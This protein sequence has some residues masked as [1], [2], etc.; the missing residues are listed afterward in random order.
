MT[1]QQAVSSLAS[2]RYLLDEMAEPERTTFEEHYFSCSECAEDVRAGAVM[3]EG[4]RAGWVPA[5]VAAPLPALGSAGRIVSMPPRRTWIQSTVVPWALAAS[6][7]MLATYQTVTRSPLPAQS[8]SEALAPV[9]L[10]PASRGQQP[11]VHVAPESASIALVADVTAAP[12]AELIYDL[13]TAEGARVVSG[14]A[15]A[16]TPGAP[17][18]LLIQSRVVNRPGHY[19][20]TIAGTDYPFEVVTP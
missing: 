12:A 18:L 19:V 17:L 20:L 7:A 2:E 11:I 13:R 10:R 9:T 4:A 16:P 14:R 1:H 6:L 15:A 5:G 3:Q 8:E